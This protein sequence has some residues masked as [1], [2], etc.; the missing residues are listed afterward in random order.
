MPDALAAQVD[1][2]YA[3]YLVFTLIFVATPGSATAVVV[4][5]AIDGGRRAGVAAALGAGLANCLHATLAGVGLS[6][7]ITT[8]PAIVRVIRV[9]GAAYLAGL[10]VVSFRRAWGERGRGYFLPPVSAKQIAVPFLPSFRDG[11]AVNLLNPSVI[12]FYV[13]VVP[14]FMP[15]PAAHTRF[16]L[17]AV[18]HVALALTFHALWALAFATVRRWFAHETARRALDAAFGLLLV[19]LALGVLF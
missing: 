16:V 18:T 9:L 1:A 12:S 5:H 2:T 4:R 10:G 8:F 14:S 17:L 6:F 11:A 13:A 7:L 3:A 15:D 19:G